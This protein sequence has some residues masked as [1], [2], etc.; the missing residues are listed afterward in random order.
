MKDNWFALKTLQYIWTHPNCQAQKVQ[1]LLR[2][3]GWQVYKRLTHHHLDLQLLP[4]MKLRCY[5]NSASASS[6]LYCQLYDYDEMNFL[7]RYLRSDDSFLDI[8]ANIGVYTLLAA[9]KIHTGSIY[10]F[11]AL[12]QNHARLQENLKLNQL[13]QVKTFAIAV[14]DQIGTVAL[15]YAD[16]DSLPA[17]STTASENSLIVPSD[18]LDHVLQDEPIAN[19]TLAKIDIEGAEL[20]ALKGAISLLQHQRPPVWIVELISPAQWEVVDFLTN[21]GYHLYS[22]RAATNQLCPFLPEQKQGNNLL[23]IADSALDFVRDRLQYAT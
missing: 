2:F 7:L 18:T 15:H 6:V 10:S 19:L 12:P 8:G 5:P 23:V 20:L 13:D 22:Y 9:A 3:F 14:S 11:E 1:A 21:F 4:G 16:G 17:I